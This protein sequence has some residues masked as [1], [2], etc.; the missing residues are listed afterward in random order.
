MYFKYRRIAK[1][2][3]GYPEKHEEAMN[4]DIDIEYLKAKIDAG[5]E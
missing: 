2:V 5:A 4:I 3:A 1:C